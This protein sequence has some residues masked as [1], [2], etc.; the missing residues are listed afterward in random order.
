[1][2]HVT[3][4][5]CVVC[6]ATYEAAPE[7]TVCACGG[8][9]EIEYD[10]AAI[11]QTVSR[12]SFARNPDRGMWRYRAFLPVEES[13]P[14]PPL[15]VGGFFAKLFDLSFTSFITVSIAKVLF[16]IAIVANA[17]AWLFFIVWGFRAGA[18]LGILALLLGWIPALVGIVFSRVGIEYFISVIRT[19]ENTRDLLNK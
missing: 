6:G 15:R 9:L 12:E 7:L 11:A 10:Y 5:R 4:A 2:T 19:A 17:L 13:S 16:V 18:P 3:C 8:V 1:M 14:S